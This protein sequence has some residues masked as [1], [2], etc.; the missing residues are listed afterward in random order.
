MSLP[1]LLL[2]N[3]VGGLCLEEIA[4]YS[5]QPTDEIFAEKTF[6]SEK[7]ISTIKSWLKQNKALVPS[8]SS[9]SKRSAN[10]RLTNY[11]AQLAPTFQRLDPEPTTDGATQVA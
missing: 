11:S 3:L 7:T 10:Y 4:P 6:E 1:L 5:V 2:N 8:V 9:F